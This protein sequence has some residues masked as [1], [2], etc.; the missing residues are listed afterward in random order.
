MTK[1]TPAIWYA[2]IVLLVVMVH[3]WVHQLNLYPC[4]CLELMNANVSVSSE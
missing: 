2:N 3:E 4:P 1:K